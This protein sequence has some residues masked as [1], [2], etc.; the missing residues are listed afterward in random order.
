VIVS[1]SQ[2]C[3]PPG[4]HI[5]LVRAITLSLN[6]IQAYGTTVETI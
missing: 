1:Y 5:W 6:D 4:R 2:G 3:A